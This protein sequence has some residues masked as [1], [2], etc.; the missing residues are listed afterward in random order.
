[1]LLLLAA[2]AV[3]LFGL[4]NKVVHIP[5]PMWNAHRLP[6]PPAMR[7]LAIRRPRCGRGWWARS[8]SAC[9]CWAWLAAHP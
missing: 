1:M 7:A 4:V 5:A 3:A 6:G 9:C 8:S 2:V